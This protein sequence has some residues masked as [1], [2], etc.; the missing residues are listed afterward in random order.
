MRFFLGYAGIDMPWPLK[1]IGWEGLR[2][3]R[4]QKGCWSL[5]HVGREG[6][7]DDLTA[8]GEDIPSIQ[9]VAVTDIALPKGFV[10]SDFPSP[11]AGLLSEAMRFRQSALVPSNFEVVTLQSVRKVV[12]SIL[13][14]KE[15][16]S[17]LKPPLITKGDVF[18]ELCDLFPGFDQTLMQLALMSRLV[19]GYALGYWD[20]AKL[21][22]GTVELKNIQQL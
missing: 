19:E 4:Q 16:H 3:M 22:S 6:F 1:R 2:D 21:Y 14:Y 9:D 20:F 17:S 13:N 11:E 10:S 8:F 7:D 15:I 5:C 18:V 12:V